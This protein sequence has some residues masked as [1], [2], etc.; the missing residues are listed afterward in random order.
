MKIDGKYYYVD[1][2]WDD[3]NYDKYTYFLKESDLF[4]QD[5][6]LSDESQKNFGDYNISKTDYDAKLIPTHT[7]NYALMKAYQSRLVRFVRM[8]K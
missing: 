8:N 2:T 3:G 6:T 4:A 7:H 1:V 5:H